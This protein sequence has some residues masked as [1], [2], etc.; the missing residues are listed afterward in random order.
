MEQK[1]NMID[2][3]IKPIDAVF[4]I[5]KQR[6]DDK[7]SFLWLLGRMAG[8]VVGTAVTLGDI[9]LPSVFPE[10]TLMHKFALPITV[11]LDYIWQRV[12]YSNNKLPEG[13]K[14][15]GDTLPNGLSG[16]PKEMKGSN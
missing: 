16:T 4:E 2:K 6:K 14:K 15:V 11:G 13:A 10:H 5:V 1:D 12:R 8:V 9:I 7:K 3:I